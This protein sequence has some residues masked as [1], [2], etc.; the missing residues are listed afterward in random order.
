MQQVSNCAAVPELAVG[1]SQQRAPFAHAGSDLISTTLAISR[2]FSP[3][4]NVLFSHLSLSLRLLLPCRTTTSPLLLHL[5]L[6]LHHQSPST[7]TTSSMTA[8]SHQGPR[9]TTATRIMIAMSTPGPSTPAASGMTTSLPALLTTTSP[10]QVLPPWY[11]AGIWPA[12]L[13][14][15]SGSCSLL[16]WCSDFLQLAQHTTAQHATAAGSRLDDQHCPSCDAHVGM[17]H[18]HTCFP[19]L[20]VPTV[21]CAMC[22]T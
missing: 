15:S 6:L 18:N 5:A 16:P 22:C 13:A 2:R 10:T 11:V 4:R 9:P 14:V 12:K 7:H 20:H 1:R 17:N 19:P 8:T 21:L 3:F